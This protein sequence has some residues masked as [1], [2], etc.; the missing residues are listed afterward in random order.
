MKIVDV[1]VLLYATNQRA[2]EYS[3]AHA[4]WVDAVNGDESIALPWPTIT[5]FL[6]L[7]T[8]RTVLAQPLTIANA[9]AIVEKWLSFEPVTLLDTSRE[10]WASYKICAID[11]DVAGNAT[12]DAQYAAQAIA[13]S[14]TLVSCDTGFARFRGLKWE[15]PLTA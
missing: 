10:L 1:N 6:R 15:N 7:V 12:Y 13:R 2:P 5:G 14:A 3:R 11:A 9:V 8:H 4:W